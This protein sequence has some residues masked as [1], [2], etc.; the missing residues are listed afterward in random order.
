MRRFAVGVA[1]VVGLA[2]TAVAG[3]ATVTIAIVEGRVQAG[4][5]DDSG[6]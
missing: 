2:A 4:R 3:A 6:R 1:V 5:E